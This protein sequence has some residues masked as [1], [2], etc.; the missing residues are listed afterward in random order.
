VHLGS[1]HG[2][3]RLTAAQP[4]WLVAQRDGD[5]GRRSASA[6][7]AAVGNS[8][9][10]AAELGGEQALWQ[11][12]G[13]VDR[14]KVRKRSGGG[15]SLELSTAVLA[16]DGETAVEARTGSR[17]GRRLGRGAARRCTGAWGRVDWRFRGV[18]AAL[19][20]GSMMAAWRCS[21]VWRAEE[22]EMVLRGAGLPL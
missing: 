9:K 10:P 6:A 17:G 3:A 7:L 15:G 20:D 1:A 5:R 13:V 2:R 18:G 14:F 12:G 21:G 16:A 8:G 22:G 4:T 11:G 19:H